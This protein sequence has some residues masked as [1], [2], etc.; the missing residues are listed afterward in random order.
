MPKRLSRLVFLAMAS[1]FLVSGCTSVGKGKDTLQTA[2]APKNSK[3][4]IYFPGLATEESK[5]ISITPNAVEDY[6]SYK[7]GLSSK[8]I[9]QFGSV[10]MT[11]VSRDRTLAPPFL[12]VDVNLE[13]ELL[14][15]YL[16]KEL[17]T[18]QK[19]MFSEKAKA[20]LYNVPDLPNRTT[21]TIS[22]QSGFTKYNYFPRV[23]IEFSAKLNTPSQLDRLAYLGMVLQVKDIVPNEQ[24]MKR[25]EELTCTCTDL[26]RVNDESKCS[27][28]KQK[29][30]E[31]C[32]SIEQQLAENKCNSRSEERW[33]CDV[34]RRNLVGLYSCNF[35]SNL[36]RIIDFQPKE[37]DIIEF[38][39]GQLTQ[40]A[41]L[42][43]KTGL[44]NQQVDVTAF[45][46]SSGPVTDLVTQGNQNTF[47]GG[48]ASEL[49]FVY[50]ETFVNALKDSIEARTAGVLD[51][52]RVFFC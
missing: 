13:K 51:E 11:V 49:A 10:D 43:A 45:G 18:A 6:E 36:S 22:A 50:S 8:N 14:A 35:D 30:S 39:R 47:T 34:A 19:E 37:A 2:A 23:N 27:S 52:G 5:M 41:Q 40:A 46:S 16:S 21:N 1:S 20:K 44:T 32:R 12:P 33:Q 9:I 4:Q 15:V 3:F 48:A 31:T 28:N 29:D 7:S 38:T 24:D 26:K 25:I 17:S 42:S